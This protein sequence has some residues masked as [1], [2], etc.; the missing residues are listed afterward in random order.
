MRRTGDG[1]LSKEGLNWNEQ[2]DASI[3]VGNSYQSIDLRHFLFRGSRLVCR[4]AVC[5]PQYVQQAI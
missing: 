2:L 1:W 4:Q 5:N 3:V